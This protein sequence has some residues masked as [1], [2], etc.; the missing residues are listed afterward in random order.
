MLVLIRKCEKLLNVIQDL[1][2]GSRYFAWAVTTFLYY[3]YFSQPPNQ[4]SGIA[5]TLLCQDCPLGTGGLEISII[6]KMKKVL[7]VVIT[8]LLSVSMNAQNGEEHMKFKGIPIDGTLSDFTQKM[9]QKGFSY[10]G[11]ED[12]MAL[13][14]GEFAATKGCTIVA[15]AKST[16]SVHKVAVAFPDCD[17]W[18]CLSNKYESLKDMLTQKYGEPSFNIEKFDD[19]YIRDDGDR[20]F[21]VR[22]DRC[23][24]ATSWIIDE[25]EIDLDITHS[26]YSSCFV[27]L[28]YI[29]G[30][31]TDKVINQAIEDL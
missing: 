12:G 13:F 6:K 11:M 4:E 10:K 18:S 3:R 9:T 1:C 24:Y 23:K 16:N 20:F 19:K 28:I 2:D 22:T 29:D 27:R 5:A 7:L 21:N 14:E 25:G 26:G 15:V 30:Q 17:T 8:L 31:N